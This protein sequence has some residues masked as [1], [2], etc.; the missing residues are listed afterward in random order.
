MLL[1]KMDSV[2]V[3]GFGEVVGF[4]KL[5]EIWAF[6]KDAKTEADTMVKGTKK[7]AMDRSIGKSSRVRD[8]G[9]MPRLGLL[10][11]MP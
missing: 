7:R 10:V 1:R 8:A 9:I 3:S 2:F 5:G 11:S 6:A 4:G